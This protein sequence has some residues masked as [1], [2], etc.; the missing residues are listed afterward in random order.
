MSVTISA[1]YNQKP[2]GDVVHAFES[3][4]ILVHLLVIVLKD[5][6]MSRALYVHRLSADNHT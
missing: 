1:C 2:G 3:I 5:R 4:F 6:G